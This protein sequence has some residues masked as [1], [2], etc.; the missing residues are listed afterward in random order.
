MINEKLE[1]ASKALITF[2]AIRG[3]SKILKLI[4]WY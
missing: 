3:K 2:F 4:T 1:E